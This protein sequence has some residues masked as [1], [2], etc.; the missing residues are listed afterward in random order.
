MVTIAAPPG[1]IPPTAGATAPARLQIQPKPVFTTVKAGTQLRRLYRPSRF[2]PLPTTFRFNGPRARFDH[3]R[4][5]IT[6]ANWISF[7]DEDAVPVPANGQVGDDPD[8]GI[9]YAAFS[10][11]C[12]V[13]EVFEAFEINDPRGCLVAKFTLT[14]D[15]KLLDLRKNGAM[16]VGTVTALAKRRHPMSQAWSRYFYEDPAFAG[17]DGLYYNAAHN[18]EAAVA[19]YERSQD[20]L[21]CPPAHL[22]GLDTRKN[23]LPLLRIADAHNLTLDPDY[24]TM[25]R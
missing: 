9:L 2:C 3:H 7:P 22:E 25:F 20:A 14:R 12:C 23:R 1:C 6:K 15:L 16:R 8:R 13:V 17:I 18:D 11:S 21:S 24:L 10:L 19:L 5:D 4:I